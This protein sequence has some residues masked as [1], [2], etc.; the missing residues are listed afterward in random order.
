MNKNNKI[1][2][3]EYEIETINQFLFFYNNFFQTE[4]FIDYRNRKEVKNIANQIHY[5]SP[6]F[7]ISPLAI[8][9]YIKYKKLY[10]NFKHKMSTLDYNV[11]NFNNRL[12]LQKIQ[13]FDNLCGKVEDKNLDYQQK[14]AIVRDYENH[15]VIAGAGSGKTTTIIGK[16]K[17]L[18]QNHYA[19]PE[20]ILVLSFTNA[21]SVE[22][23]NR[24]QQEIHQP[25]DVYT[26]HKLGLEIIK[27]C[28]NQTINIYNKPLDYFIRE[29]MVELSRSNAY[30][31]MLI[32]F[33]SNGRYE[34]IDTIK[35]NNQSE[36][37]DYLR[38][39]PPTTL[40]GEVVK[41][42]GE[43]EIANYLYTH[44]VKYI[45]EDNYKYKKSDKNNPPYKPD[46]YLPDYNIYIEYFGIDENGN[47]PSY[48]STPLSKSAKEAYN[49]SI[50][51]K[52]RTHLENETILIE[53][54]AYEKQNKSLIENLHIHLE[55]QGVISYRKNEEDIWKDIQAKNYGIIGE[56]SRTFATIIN[57]IKS[58]GYS[59]EETL[60]LVENSSHSIQN[61]LVLYLIKP[62]YEAY[63][64]FLHYTNQID[65]NDM[66]NLATTNLMRGQYTHNYKYVI[67]DEYQDISKSRFLLLSALRK[68]KRY[69][70]F[71]VGDDWQSIYRF[72]GSDVGLMINFE[73]YWGDTYINRIETTYRFSNKLAKISGDFIMKNHFQI[74]KNINGFQSD[75]FPLGII[76][77]YTENNC[78]K[79]LKRRLQEFEYGSS[80]F[81]IGRY[82]FDIEI[83]KKDKDFEI[84]Y[85][86]VGKISNIKYKQNPSLKMLFLT[87]HKAKGLQADYVII[88]NN[89]KLGLGFPCKILDI[90]IINLLLEKNDEFPNAEE[91]RLFYVAI[92]RSKKKTLLLTI[93]QN[94]SVFVQELYNLYERDFSKEKYEC[95]K[96]GGRLCLKEGPYSKFWGCSNY[97]S[98]TYIRK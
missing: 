66:I 74:S 1:K 19:K 35:F 73:K 22:L 57:L 10:K 76:G 53:C 31:S 17:Y 28:T 49:D 75:F 98:C 80:V 83:I 18:V 29:Q 90:P 36:Y 69:K 96:C 44:N 34:N 85:D 6:F 47:V 88:L 32:D 8:I 56:I 70:L 63:N 60:N 2:K 42:Y 62:I 45:Y 82:N 92:T 81:L 3:L 39:N 25:M 55:A 65:F 84:W 58:I 4:Q 78:M 93:A 89:K 79:A 26:F 21:S 94:E 38:N 52:R 14:D 9:K 20:E 59:Y 95:P 15:L 48:F 68:I 61:K 27:S 54:Y 16:I 43:M 13:V 86:N 30:L 41:S 40:N 87:A 51:W 33:I 64:N 97:P 12:A 46:F 67:I 77:G 5:V 50:K 37:N 24:I 7:S 23:K 71:C 72:S 91:R 11:E